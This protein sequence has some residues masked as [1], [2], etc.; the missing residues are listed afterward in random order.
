M[1]QEQTK[2]LDIGDVF[3]IEAAQELYDKHRVA[4]IITDGRYIQIEKEPT[5]LPAK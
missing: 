4:T 1:I 5:S 3:T 2:K